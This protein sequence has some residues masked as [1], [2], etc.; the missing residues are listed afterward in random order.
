MKIPLFSA[1]IRAPEKAGKSNLTHPEV[2]V[3]LQARYGVL[4]VAGECL[5]YV[6]PTPGHSDTWLGIWSPR[7]EDDR[8]VQ[9]FQKRDDA[10]A[11]V[12]SLQPVANGG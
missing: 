9:H 3:A 4:N 6:L 1:T 10:V 12:S 7:S 8:C 2:M 5:G 11:H